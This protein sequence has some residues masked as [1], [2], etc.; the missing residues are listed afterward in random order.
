M[1]VLFFAYISSNLEPFEFWENNNFVFLL[2]ETAIYGFIVSLL[3]NILDIEIIDCMALFNYACSRSVAWFP[4][5]CLFSLNC[6][7]CASIFGPC[8]RYLRSALCLP[9]AVKC[10]YGQDRCFPC[11]IFWSLDTDK[12]H[13]TNIASAFLLWICQ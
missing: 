5:L 1:L 8:V 10:D 4:C 11:T 7:S 12:G 3:T 2:T 9:I 6:C 13:C